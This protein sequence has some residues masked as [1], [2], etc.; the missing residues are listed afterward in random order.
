MEDKVANSGKRSAS[1]SA[2]PEDASDT[3]ADKVGG[4]R[5]RSASESPPNLASPERPANGE[6][7]AAPDASGAE[8]ENSKSSR[9]R[10]ASRSSK[11]LSSPDPTGHEKVS[12]APDAS[13][14]VVDEAK[15]SRERSAS[16]DSKRVASPEPSAVKEVTGESSELPQNSPTI[17]PIAA[18]DASSS[19]VDEASGHKVEVLDGQEA[20]PQPE[21]SPESAQAEPHP[22]PK[23]LPE[24]AQV[25]ATGAVDDLDKLTVPKLKEKLQRFK[26]KVSGV[27]SELVARLRAH[28]GGKNADADAA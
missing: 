11:R 13:D 22:V 15:D 28:L 4:S 27:K 25:Q 9:K 24:S 26:L 19:V 10:S 16:R 12:A 14:A 6:A 2:K 20:A 8:V 23:A 3:N 17:E 7:S 1:R 5:E 21:A 18:T